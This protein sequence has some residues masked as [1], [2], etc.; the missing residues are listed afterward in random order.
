MSPEFWYRL[1]FFIAALLLTDILLYFGLKRLIP[2]KKK[3]KKNKRS[4]ALGYF[5]LTLLYIIYASSHFLYIIN[6][7]ENYESYRQL[8]FIT[9]AFLIL[10]LPKILM[11][12]FITAERILLFFIQ[13]ISF[14]FQH[15]KH[16][17]FVRALHRF[18]LFSWVGYILG[19]CLFAYMIHGMINTRTDF[20]IREY[21]IS[22]KK[23]PEKFDGIRILHISDTH[24]GS[25]FSPRELE[26]AFTKMQEAHP[27]LIVFTGDM[28]NI[29]AAEATPYVE[30]FRKLNAPLGKFAVLGNHDQDDY[31]KVKQLQTSDPEDSV[32]SGI[33][34][35]MGFE[36]LRNRNISIKKDQDS[37][38]LIGVDSWGLPPFRQRGKLH[39]AMKGTDSRSFS[40]LL[41]HIPTHWS[42][43]VKGSTNIDLTLAGHTHA[44][45]LAAEFRGFRW[46][47]VQYFYPEYWGLYYWGRQVLHV[48]PGLGY[49]GFPGRIGVPPEITVLTLQRDQM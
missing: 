21:N 36:L 3:D 12:I 39:E 10:Y 37:I 41:S 35:S 26:P 15:K 23:L 43:E 27:D 16:Y 33:I 45:Q 42:V 48:N 11:L 1:S 7:Y 34:T 9:G 2:D 46:S 17:D 29:E 31:M 5:G 25:F 44:M 24:L 6:N 32:L 13:F 14:L 22:F 38:V 47:P 49:L 40:I 8:F 4:F 20:Q 30:F 19:W 18:K 28:I